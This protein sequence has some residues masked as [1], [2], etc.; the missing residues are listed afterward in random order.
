[1]PSPCGPTV[2]L[3][4][5]ESRLR[6]EACGRQWTLTHRDRPLR[7]G[8]AADND[9]TLGDEFT[10]RYHGTVGWHDGRFAVT[11]DS[12]NGT[13]VVFGDGVQSRLHRDRCTLDRQG[14]LHLG[15]PTSIAIAFA[16]EIR[17]EPEGQWGSPM[18]PDVNLIRR[19]GDYWTL[20]YAGRLL[21]MKDSKGLR[22]LAHLL[23]HPR[24]EFHVLDLVALVPSKDTDT[25]EG[26]GVSAM[27]PAR[28]VGPA[29][30]A[31]ARAAYRQRLE[32]LREE[33]VEAETFH[34]AGRVPRL[35]AEIGALMEQLSAAVGL[36]GRDRYLGSDADRARVAVTQRL[37]EVIRRIVRHD[38]VLGRHLQTTVRTGR[39]CTYCGDET[40]PS[41]WTS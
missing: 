34:D 33:L 8:R 9:L 35:R 37:K 23:Q 17:T 32:E 40:K 6:L 10:S 36:G 39:F 14:S 21:Q 15:H 16:I 11:D 31:T 26:V 18:P 30:D 4:T 41:R 5:I 20:R 28:D 2:N 13:F 38:A 29:L 22:Y 3:T 7:F 12:R 1:M 19:D 25:G 27:A 24:R